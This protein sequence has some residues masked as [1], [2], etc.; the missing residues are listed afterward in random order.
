MEPKVIRLFMWSYQHHFRDAVQ[1]CMTDVLKELGVPDARPECFLVGVRIRGQEV[2]NEVCLEPED[3]EWRL[4][5]FSSVLG[6]VEKAIADGTTE[7]ITNVDEQT[8]RDWSEEKYRF[9]V[10][11]VL[12]ETLR[13]CDSEH[14][15]R[16]FVRIAGDVGQY[17]VFPVIQ[18]PEDLFERFTPLREPTRDGVLSGPPSLIH[19]AVA[20][21]LDEA[22]EE[23]RRQDPGRQHAQ[24]FRSTSE[25]VRQA[26]VSFM[27]TPSVAIRDR[28]VGPDLLMQ[29]NRVSASTY[30]GAEGA[31]RL[32]LS[33]EEDGLLDFRLRF[34]DPVSFRDLRGFRKTLQMASL[35]GVLL[36]DSEKILGLGR[37]RATGAD[38]AP[39]GSGKVFEV[40]FVGR[41][42][43]RLSSGEEVLLVCRNGVPSLPRPDIPDHL[44][45]TYRRLFPETGEADAERF[46]KLFGA[47]VEQG[48]GSMLIVAEDAGHEAGRLRGE[49]AVVDPVELTSDLYRQ[50]SRID[51]AILVDPSCVCHAVGVILDGMTQPECRASRGARYNSGVRYV[52]AEETSRRLAIIVSD[53]GMV[54]V[55]P[56]PRPRVSRAD[57]E[58]LVVALEAA[59]PENGRR[60]ANSVDRMRFYLSEEQCN[61]VNRAIERI[62]KEII[63]AGEIWFCPDEFRRH[64]RLDRTYF[65]EEA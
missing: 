55:I 49:G 4:D 17:H 22:R 30:E 32:V 37:V 35:G 58:E 21:V 50:V 16:S 9:S 14:G 28:S 62:Y 44:E 26:G 53:D 33:N 57:I 48:H 54:D 52:Y 23:L 41:H 60:V 3:G 12:L 64:P 24:R 6:D 36:A 45:D 29:F 2:R 7:I 43:W 46:L 65:K 42:H 8:W 40:E 19:A 18:L 51:G 10:G 27:R 20:A 34:A 56:E 25:I 39:L 1:H 38:D 13:E 63:E 11:G 47:A 61:R 15:V 31:G 59:G 5:L